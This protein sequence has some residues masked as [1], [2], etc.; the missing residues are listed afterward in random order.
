MYVALCLACVQ[1]VGS[2][3]CGEAF[4]SL[5]DVAMITSVLAELTHTQHSVVTP[6][7]IRAMRGPCSRCG[8]PSALCRARGIVM[9]QALQHPPFDPMM[10]HRRTGHS[11]VMMA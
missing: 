2:V 11:Y 1:G 3:S 4:G 9:D 7:H 8:A 5:L 10:A 6:T